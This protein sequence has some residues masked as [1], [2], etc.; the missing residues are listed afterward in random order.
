MRKVLSIFL[1]ALYEREKKNNWMEK[2]HSAE[3]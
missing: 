3:G 2:Y 1:F